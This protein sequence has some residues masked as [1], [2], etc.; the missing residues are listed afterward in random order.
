MNSSSEEIRRKSLPP[1]I[2]RHSSGVQ[3]DVRR[4]SMPN[5]VTQPKKNRRHKRVTFNADSRNS[6]QNSYFNSEN[7]KSFGIILFR[8]FHN[9]QLE[10]LIKK[11]MLSFRGKA[12][13]VSARSIVFLISILN[14]FL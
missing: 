11:E 8:K 14:F 3:S 2:S 10:F 9:G 4:P 5:S 6:S 1:P 12:V 7:E 13:P